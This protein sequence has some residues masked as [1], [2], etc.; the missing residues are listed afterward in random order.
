MLFFSNKWI[1]KKGKWG[2][3]EVRERK[4]DGRKEG[5]REEEGRERKKE[6][7]RKKDGRRGRKEIRGQEGRREEGKEK[8]KTQWFNTIKKFVVV[9]LIITQIFLVSSLRQWG[10]S[11]SESQAVFFLQSHCLGCVASG[12]LQSCEDCIRHSTFTHL[13]PL[14][15]LSHFCLFLGMVS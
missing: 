3:E 11:D 14:I 5:E 9:V 1:R 4:K 13:S 10:R 7:G 12:L 15:F 8:E 6:E 2:R